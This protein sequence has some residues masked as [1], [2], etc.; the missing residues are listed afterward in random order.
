M[1][2]KA[3]C[4]LNPCLYEKVD[5]DFDKLADA[6]AL[7]YRRIHKLNKVT[8]WSNDWTLVENDYE[9]KDKKKKAVK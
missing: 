6:L 4:S 7:H 1:A 3:K 2:Y 9:G 5:E 8:K